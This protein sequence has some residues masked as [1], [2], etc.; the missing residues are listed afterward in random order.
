LLL[1]VVACASPQR[2]AAECGDYVTILNA[3]PGSAHHAMPASPDSGDAP[4]RAPCHGPN[5]QGAPVKHYPPLA[6]AAPVGPQAKEQAQ[7]LESVGD[8]D[9]PPAPFDRDSSSPRPVKR[10]SSVFH[11]P[12]LG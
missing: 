10:A 6:P 1:V 9:A 8:A 2:A 3:P 11:P 4:A 12:R 5:C 7:Y